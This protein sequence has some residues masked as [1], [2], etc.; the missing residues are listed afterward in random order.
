[1]SSAY[2]LFK[3]AVTSGEKELCEFSGKVTIVCNSNFP[4]I[5]WL[6]GLSLKQSTEDSCNFIGYRLLF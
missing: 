6:F 4:K 5:K 2:L 3:P 1:M